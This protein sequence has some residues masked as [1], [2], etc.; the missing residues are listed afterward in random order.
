MMKNKILL[1]LCMSMPLLLVGCGGSDSPSSA[2]SQGIS[3][4]TITGFGSVFVNGVKFNT[5]GATITRGDDDDN[6]IEETELEIGMVVRVEG[7]IQNRIASSISFEEDV[8]G[9]ADGGVAADGTFS[10]MGQTI[11]INPVTVLDEGLSLAGIA[12]DDILEIS[13]LRNVDDDIVA[14]FIEKKAG[15]ADV[16]RYSVIGHVRALD[17]NAKTFKID[18]LLIDYNGA[19]VNDFI[20]GHPGE[21][22]LVEVKDDFKIYVAGSN[23]LNATKVEPHNRLGEDR[24]SVV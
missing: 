22:Q 7:D 21:G 4:G 11:I 14:S 18:N 5:D 16:R 8:K 19:S 23:S 12:S 24:K 1:T 17:T 6:G 13:G 15:P 20:N 3:S 2:S 10:V 9:P